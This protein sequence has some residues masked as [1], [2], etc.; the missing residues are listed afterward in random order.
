M[1]GTAYYPNHSLAVHPSEVCAHGS[2]DMV[3]H[4]W[5]TS[6]AKISDLPTIKM[7]YWH[8]EAR[9]DRRLSCYVMKY[10]T[11]SWYL[12]MQLHFYGEIY[13]DPSKQ[14][15]VFERYQKDTHSPTVPHVSF[16]RSPKELCEEKHLVW[17]N[18][19]N[20]MLS[21]QGTKTTLHIAGCSWYRI[22]IRKQRALSI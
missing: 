22:Y 11:V 10:A 18:T 12:E 8:F 19:N 3:F 5:S 21:A 9:M 14:E 17:W 15:D 7:V 6:A 13:Q 4:W 20:D 16:G 1:Y 2:S